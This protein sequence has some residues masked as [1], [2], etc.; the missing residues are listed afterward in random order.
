[1]SADAVL[2][3]S[4]MHPPDFISTEEGVSPTTIIITFQIF[5]G[6]SHG[7][8]RQR[9]SYDTGILTLVPTAFS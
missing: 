2:D 9:F 5:T 6:F 8:K 7:Y 3:G 1:M 4:P